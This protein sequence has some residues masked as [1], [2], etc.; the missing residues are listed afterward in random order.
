MPVSPPGP[1]ALAAGLAA[2]GRAAGWHR[3]VLA[4][5]LAGGAAALGLTALAPPPAPTERVVAA[6]RDLAP[7]SPVAGQD[8]A[9][10]DLPPAAVPDGALRTAGEAVGRLP[11]GPVRRG[12]PLT[13]VRLAGPGLLAGLGPGRVAAPVR[14]AD[15]GAAALLRPG[16]RVDVLTTPLVADTGAAGDGTAGDEGAGDGTVTTG[17][18]T[19]ARAPGPVRPTAVPVARGVPVLA[20]PT[21]QDGDTGT[22][23]VLA[24]DGS[25]AA[26]LA[27]AATSGRLSV[28]LRGP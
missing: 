1:P 21:G 19:S 5:G 24:T 9:L 18:G 25:T 17:P 27:A 12:E 26:A 23:V 8:V 2:L 28:V 22:L 6:A 7:G 14:L 20:V 3:R 13:D 15:P 11:A 4:A 16:D 10:V